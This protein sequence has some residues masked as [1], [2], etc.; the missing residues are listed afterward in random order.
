MMEKIAWLDCPYGKINDPFPGSCE[1]YI[2]TNQDL[3]CDRSEP[4][5]QTI[6][7]A[8]YLIFLTLVFYFLHWYLVNQTKLS[9]KLKWLKKSFF[10]YFWNLILLL[11]FLATAISGVLLILGV[12]SAFLPSL[13][14]Q[15]GIVF[16]VIGFL[17]LF[18]RIQY[19]LRKP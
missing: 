3:I 12:K 13:H 19:F 4:T 6:N 7:P 17:H 11:T 2:D 1:L 10:C 9:K 14:N 18:G 8:F 16:V 5:P 15:L